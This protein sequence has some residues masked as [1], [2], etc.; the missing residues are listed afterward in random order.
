MSD[1]VSIPA[2]PGA[3]QVY[4]R[5]Y[6]RYDGP[7]GG[8]WAAVRALFL[9]S[10][11]RALG[12]RRSWKQKVLPWLLLAVT[13]TPAAVFVGVGYVTRNTPAADFEFITYRDYVGVSTALLLF[14]AVTAPDL[15]CPE[16]RQRVLP[17]IFSRPLTGR[18][19]VLAKAGAVF[20]VVFVFGLLPQ[21]LLFVGQMLVS[22]AALT[23]LRENAEILW[24][25]PLAVAVLAA[26]L[27]LLGTAVASLASRRMVAAAAF[28]GLLLVSST[29]SAVLLG[30]SNHGSGALVNVIGIPLFVRDL[31][32]LG[33]IG[34]ETP[35]G[36]VDGGGVLAVA[37]YLGVTGA[38]V[39]VLLARYRWAER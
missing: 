25:A 12:L 3:G 39:A 31:V 24:Q 10:I 20:T 1:P 4:D 37:C 17:L 35:L 2:S 26:F 32:F 23:Y 18:D 7:R 34:D 27:A 33:H 29:V 9:G 6:R 21:V 19:Y 30:S 13:A 36:G 8:R 5:G 22:D 11:R 28:L 16:R 15:I 14:V 38:C